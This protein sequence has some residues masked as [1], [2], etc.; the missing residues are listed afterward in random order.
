MNCL[1]LSRVI[2]LAKS[3][4]LEMITILLELIRYTLPALVVYFLM[5]QF[6]RGHQATEQMKVRSTMNSDHRALRMQAY[7][8]LM[9]FCERID[10]PALLMRLNNEDITA[11]QLKNVLLISIQKEYEHNLTQQAYISGQLW[12]M[13]TFL[14]DKTI[15]VIGAVYAAGPSDDKSHLRV[16]W[17]EENVALSQMSKKV[18]DAI[19]KELE[20]YFQ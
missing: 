11:S 4:T 19:R 18:K 15:D 20:L 6:I 17:M 5:R 13:V 8:R 7:E 1:I 14:K 9:L 3:P 12:D 10:V 16:R 2:N